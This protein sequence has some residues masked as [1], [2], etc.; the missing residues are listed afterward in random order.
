MRCEQSA[1]LDRPGYC[2][3]RRTRPR[4]GRRAAARA[5]PRRSRRRAG[6]SSGAPRWRTR[7]R[8]RRR[9]RAPVAVHHARIQPQP[10]RG[11]HLLGAAVHADHLT[12]QRD[13]L[14]GQRAVAAA[15]IEDA[16]ARLAAPA[17][18]RPACPGLRRSGRCERIV[19]DSRFG[20]SSLLYIGLR[21]HLPRLTPL[22]DLRYNPGH[23][24][25]SGCALG[26]HRLRRHVGCA[27]HLSVLTI[28]W[29]DHVHCPHHRR[30]DRWVHPP[31]WRS[32]A[33]AQ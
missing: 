9:S 8:T 23:G 33:R 16:L 11:R 7:H 19:R 20:C 10:D 2:L 17:A 1:S 21:K 5:P 6:A 28:C 13:E 25:V 15:Q 22:P 31:A 29:V 4:S 30:N 14:G 12:A 24:L 26:S 18:R 3:R 32:L 27:G